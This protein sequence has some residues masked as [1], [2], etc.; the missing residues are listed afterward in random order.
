MKKDLQLD[1]CIVKT[2]FAVTFGLA[3]MLLLFTPPAF[4]CEKLII[5][6]HK[7]PDTDS[8]ISAIAYATLKNLMGVKEAS[9]AVA[10]PINSETRFVLD[11]FKV[12][13]PEMITDCKDQCKQVI[14]VDHNEMAQTVDNLNMENVV[15]VLD[16]HRIGG[17]TSSKAISFLDEPVG[18]TASIVA[19]LYEQNKIPISREMAGLMLSAILSDT[20]LLKSPTSTPRDADTVVKLAGIAGIDD[21]KKFGIELLR[22]KSNIASRSAYDLVT[23]DLKKFNFSGT[24]AAVGQIEV[25]DLNDLASKRAS[26]L[27]EMN[28]LMDRE[29]LDMVVMMLTDVIKETSDLLFV[30]SAAAAVGFE[31]AFSG[32]IIDNSIYRDKVLSRKLQVIPPLDNAFKN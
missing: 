9:P 22:A 7:N 32:K 4:A 15:E 5:I 11:H 19:N 14:L 8:V 29:K 23:G 16:H 21:P 25:M 2:R 3:V 24:K 12:P 26:M 20:V 10:G 1:R 17:F 27:E 30:G 13:Y 31:K 6:G 18:A 28:K